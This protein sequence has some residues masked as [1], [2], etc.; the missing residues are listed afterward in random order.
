M[1]HTI[2][3]II[4]SLF[5]VSCTSNTIYKK[6][7]DLIPKDQMID[8][9]V[10]IQLALGGKAGKNLNGNYSVDYMP[11]V[12]EKYNIDSARF[13]RSSF[14]YHTDIDNDN[15]I[16]L[17]VRQRLNDLNNENTRLIEEKEA[18]ETPNLELNKNDNQ[19]LWNE[20]FATKP[21][22]FI[23][24]NFE[25]KKGTQ[26]DSLLKF[27]KLIATKTTNGAWAKHG[28]SLTMNSEYFVSS[29]FKKGTKRKVRLNV[30]DG[31]SDIY[32]TIDL[33]KNSLIK[34]VGIKEYNI[35]SVDNEWHRVSITFNSKITT[36]AAQLQI[37]FEATKLNTT[38]Y[39]Y[40][41][42]TT[43]EKINNPE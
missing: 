39:F 14:F 32:V 5:L 35:E 20:N 9:L 15:Q 8:V 24:A 30:F 26:N 34:R 17:K 22:E 38:D 16:L 7:D 2:Y 28:I 37:R 18:A 27:N 31:K 33:I 3:I 13:A 23:R 6:P 41:R 42:G 36:K 25:A 1:K 40:F 12:F 4:T 21:W 19:I 29:Y 43:F 11:L 10:D